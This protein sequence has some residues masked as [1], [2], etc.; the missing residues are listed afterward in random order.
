MRDP[1]KQLLLNL[2]ACSPILA[3]AWAVAAT[4]MEDDSLIDMGPFVPA[5]LVFLVLFPYYIC[6]SLLHHGVM[7]L[8]RSTAVVVAVMN[9]AGLLFSGIVGMFI[10]KDAFWPL[11]SGVFLFSAVTL[12]GFLR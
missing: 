9:T 7:R 3:L 2:F 1:K 11:Y 12:N 5:V 10:F 8:F 4:Q 6:L